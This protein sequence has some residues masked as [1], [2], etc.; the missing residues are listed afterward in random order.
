MLH[1]LAG[2]QPEVTISVG[3]A[4]AAGRAIDLNAL[5][6]SADAALYRAKEGGRNRTVV[7]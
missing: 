1:D 5:M 7:G 2:Q 4:S 3:V 6:A